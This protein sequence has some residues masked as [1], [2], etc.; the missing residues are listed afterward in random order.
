MQA[1]VA[2]V[3]LSAPVVELRDVAEPSCSPGQVKVRV[4]AAGIC[5]SDVHFVDELVQRPGAVPVVLGHEFAGTIA[6]TAPD[7]KAPAVGD[8]V[9]V[10][11]SAF[12]TCGQCA[13]CREGEY[14]M[15]AKRRGMGTP[16]YADGGFASFCVMPA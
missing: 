1:L 3:G 10:L 6:E 13:Y 7:V 14:C 9:I 16:G 11:P 15:C 5:G 12:S 8:R 2:D 4:E